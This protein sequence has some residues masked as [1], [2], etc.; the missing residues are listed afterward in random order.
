MDVSARMKNLVNA[1]VL[2]LDCPADVERQ[3]RIGGAQGHQA[4]T[5]CASPVRQ[6]DDLVFMV[7]PREAWRKQF[8]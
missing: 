2:L 7:A 8:P 5:S 4:L 1:L 3:S 6:E